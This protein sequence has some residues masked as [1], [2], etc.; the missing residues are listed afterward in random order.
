MSK[1][2]IQ[3]TKE[4]LDLFF[5][6]VLT[7][8]AAKANDGK[9]DMNDLPLLMGLIPKIGPAFNDINLIPAELKDLDANEAAE[10]QAFILGK[11]GQVLNKEDIVEQIN[12][13]LN[14]VV[15][16]HKFALSFK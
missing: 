15:A 16:I 4:V 5:T 8:K 10:L 9:I 2:G 13:G 7:G 3:N 1:Y 14:A 12:L 11:F 6:G